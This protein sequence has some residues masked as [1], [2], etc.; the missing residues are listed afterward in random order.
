MDALKLYGFWAIVWALKLTFATAVLIPALYGAQTELSL[1]MQWPERVS[2]GQ[3]TWPPFEL[4][5]RPEDRAC[6]AHAS[7]LLLGLEGECCPTPPG[8]LLDCCPPPRGPQPAALLVGWLLNALLWTTGIIIFLAD[9]LPWYNV[10][11][12]L[13]G[14][15]VGLHSAGV[16]RGH[17]RWE[18]RDQKQMKS[19]AVAKLMPS[20]ASSEAEVCA[21]TAEA[22]AVNAGAS[23]HGA[24]GNVNALHDSS[25]A[26]LDAA[27]E[28]TWSAI[29]N[30]LYIECHITLGEREALLDDRAV[31]AIDIQS[32][33]ARRRLG[34][35]LRSLQA[36]EM[37]PSDGALKATSMTCLIPVYNEPM[38][39]FLPESQPSPRASPNSGSN[40]AGGKDGKAANLPLRTSPRA[41][42]T[43]TTWPPKRG[44]GFRQL[45]KVETNFLKS[46]FEADWQRF[47]ERAQRREFEG[48][49]GGRH[50]QERVWAS[51]RYQTVSRTIRGLLKGWTAFDLH[52]QAE[53]PETPP[54]GSG[55]D[56]F[57][58]ADRHRLA[59]SKFRCL[60]ALQAYDTYDESVLADVEALFASQAAGQGAGLAVGYISKSKDAKGVM[61]F[62]SCLID[63]ARRDANG[64]LLTEE[65][66][67]D[68]DGST[69]ALLVPTYR[70]ELPGDPIYNGKADNQ[71]SNFIFTRGDIVQAIDCNQEGYLEESLKLPCVLSEFTR[72]PA[73]GD[74]PTIVG[75]REHIF[76]GIG[77]MGAFAAGGELC[78]GTLVQRTMAYPLWSRYHYGHPDYL[79]KIAQ[80]GQG[81]HAH[82]SVVTQTQAPSNPNP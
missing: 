12:S 56:G 31:E 62:Y 73:G 76:S 37:P 81:E 67:P 51:Q 70:V 63:G 35:L 77:A 36:K 18:A 5:P 23:S 6:A 24:S 55:L 7:C 46:F 27:W 38:M 59:S 33:E 72:A 26:R 3:A 29:V 66:A 30:E 1:A 48:L 17:A 43:P 40:G 39:L 22:E 25:R 45:P 53:L 60:A 75:F 19:A 21:L 14:G 58:A 61:R 16:A 47:E 4:R 10:V 78:F 80:I 28:R 71:N 9:T 54:E 74:P 82:S 44:N 68:E 8:A 11:L 15:L 52:L 65:S 34:F 49:P 50:Q 2:S 57:S 41:A 64:A 69:R 13:W 20:L 79:D 32:V 42:T